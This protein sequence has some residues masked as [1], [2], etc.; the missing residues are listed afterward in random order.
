MV[1]SLTKSSSLF[2]LCSE[3]VRD[4]DLYLYLLFVTSWLMGS[5]LHRTA[6]R[7]ALHLDKCRIWWQIMQW[8]WSRPPSV[9]FRRYAE[10]LMKFVTVPLTSFNASYS[11]NGSV[12]HTSKLVWHAES[13]AFLNRTEFGLSLTV[14]VCCSYPQAAPALALC[15]FF[16]VFAELGCDDVREEIPCC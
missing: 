9:A 14:F 4:R 12:A 5:S 16:L 7:M 15:V 2:F 11:T 13:R 10:L 8:P 3:S 6:A 1:L